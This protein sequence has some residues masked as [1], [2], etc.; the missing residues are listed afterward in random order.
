MNLVN[1]INGILWSNLLIYILLGAGV[2]FT[3]RLRF[4]QFRRIGDMIRLLIDKEAGDEGI[5]SFQALALSIAGRVGVGNIA[6]V[7]TAIHFGGPG[8]VFWMWCL[9]LLGSA[10]AFIESTL[11]QIYKEEKDGEYRGGAAYYLEKCTGKK[12]WGVIFACSLLYTS[13]IGVPWLQSNA[14]AASMQGAFGIPP[15]I[16]GGVVAALIALIILGGVKRIGRVAEILVPFMAIAYIIV[17]II[18]IVAKI[19][20]LPGVIVLI[21]KSAFGLEQAFA[22]IFGAAISWGVKRGIYSNE[23]GMG[24]ATQAAAAA[25]VSHPA[26]QGLVQAFSVYIDTMLVCTATAFMIIVTGSY[27]VVGSSGDYI[28]NNL[29]NVEAGPLYT[30]MAVDTVLPGFGGAFV[31]IAL[32]FFA[33]TTIIAYYYA[34]ETNTVYIKEKTGI[35]IAPFLK[36]S[37]I[38]LTFI[39]AVKTANLAWGIADIG[40]GLVTWVNIVGILIAGGVAVKALKDYDDQRSQGIDPVFDPRK[41]GIKNAEVWNKISDRNIQ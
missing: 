21:F 25:N 40:I 22:G 32:L 37:T 20:D 34:G 31:S 17:A 28:I 27:N 36:I 19:T 26:K 14:I 11:A 16:T 30:Q 1:A 12:V 9:A 13:M 2:Y 29:P 33:F 23:A 10:T 39:G 7:A 18:I 4:V 35:N 41:L 3:F 5:S 24:T 6:G 15:M 8:A 38:A